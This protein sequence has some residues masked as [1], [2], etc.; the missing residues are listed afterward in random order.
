MANITRDRLP[1]SATPATPGA[2]KAND[3]I[4]SDT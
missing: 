2:N 4:S 1:I 3:Q